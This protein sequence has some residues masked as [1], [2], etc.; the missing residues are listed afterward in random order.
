M[1]KVIGKF[2]NRGYPGTISR[3]PDTIITSF[4]CGQDNIQ[5]GMPVVLE[6][7]KLVPFAAGH[8]AD[9]F[10]GIAVRVVKQERSQLEETCYYE[11]DA[12]DVLTRGNISVRIEE[13]EP[14]TRH[15]VFVR[16]ADGAFLAEDDGACIKLDDVVFSASNLDARKVSEVAVLTR[17]V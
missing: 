2:L 8:T 3:S 7:G 14:V 13:G 9:D 11:G 4:P 12:V 1:A 17:R 16:P 5:F 10:L 15:A 6:D